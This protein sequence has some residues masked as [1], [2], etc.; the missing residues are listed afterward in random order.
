[1]LCNAV[2]RAVYRRSNINL[3]GIH[4][5]SWTDLYNIR[6]DVSATAKYVLLRS[7]RTTDADYVGIGDSWVPISGGASDP[8]ARCQLDM[9]GF[10]IEGL[11][12]TTTS[13]FTGLFGLV[14]FEFCCEN[15]IFDGAVIARAGSGQGVVVGRALHSSPGWA[16]R[17]IR[18]KNSFVNDGIASVGD[19]GIVGFVGDGRG[20]GGV[21][22][23]TTDGVIEDCSVENCRIGG[24]AS[25]TGNYNGG[26]SGWLRG[27]TIRRCN[28]RDTKI[29]TGGASESLSGGICIASGS[30]LVEDCYVDGI[31]FSGY[32][33]SHSGGIASRTGTGICTIRRCWVG[34]VDY[35]V[36]TSAG[37]RRA[38]ASAAS[39]TV[40]DC[41]YDVDGY[42]W[43]NA[44]GGT[45]K[46]AAEMCQQA[47]YAGWDFDDVWYIREGEDY[48]RLRGMAI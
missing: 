39:V 23:N 15:G 30:S 41:Y 25:G 37:N 28:V 18:V 43:E 13:D 26:I 16:F 2:R 36:T 5:S 10:T 12:T 3:D 7:L 17:K 11:T 35:S 27:G 45:A 32:R 44:G 4:V 40:S 9:N 47:T 24:S 20:A 1:M 29:D 33:A 22:G 42:A 46:T 48:P 8:L 38:I 6:N 19:G 31:S 21:D 34:D 14:G